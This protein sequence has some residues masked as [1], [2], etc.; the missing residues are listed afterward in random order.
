MKDYDIIEVLSDQQIK[1]L[2]AGE[3]QST[4]PDNLSDALFTVRRNVLT[5]SGIPGGIVNPSQTNGTA[6]FTDNQIHIGGHT[7]FYIRGVSL[8]TEEQVI[9]AVSDEEAVLLSVGLQTAISGYPTDIVRHSGMDFV[10]LGVKVGMTLVLEEGGDAGSHQIIKLN[11]GGLGVGLLQVDP[12]P[13]SPASNLRYKIVDEID[14][15]L[16]EPKTVRGSGT[17]LRTILGNLQVSTV[18]EID[19]LSM[20]ASTGDTLRISGNT[21]NA[22]DYDVKQISGTGNK[23]L[24]LGTDMRRTSSSEAW[25]LFKLQDG[26]QAPVVRITSVDILDSSKQPTGDTIP[27]AAPVD[28]QSSAFSN[29]GVGE[30][31]E[32]TDARVGILG[33]QDI[34]TP[35]AIDGKTL[36]ISINGGIFVTVTFSSPATP[37]DIVDQINTTLVDYKVAALYSYEGEIRLSLRSRNNWIVVNKL[38]TANALLGFSTVYNEDNRQVFSSLDWTAASLDIEA[39]KDAVYILTGDN[40]EFWYLQ[41]IESGSGWSRLLIVRVDEGGEAVFPLTDGRVS[42]RIGSRSFGKVRCYF[43]D[44]TS[45]E[46]RGAYRRAA[47]A[48]GVHEANKVFGTILTDE[49]PRTEFQLDLYGDQSAYFKFFPDPSLN[50]YLLPVSGETV[51]DNLLVT[52]G[53]PYVTSEQNPGLSPGQFSR[54]SEIDFLLREARPGDILEIT[55]M[56]LQSPTVALGSLVFPD[57]VVGKTLVF[58]LENGPERTVTFTNEVDGVTRLL[59]Q[60]NSQ[61][62]LTVAFVEDTGAAQYL[63]FEADVLFELRASGT[64]TAVLGMDA[65]VGTNEARAKG[66][67]VIGDVGYVSPPTSDHMRLEIASM[68]DNPSWTAFTAGQS[69]PSQHFKVYRPGVQRVSATD[70]ENNAEGSLY[71]ADIELVSFGPGDEFNIAASQQLQASNYKADGYRLTNTD[72]NLA[73]SA[74]EEL[75]MHLSRRILTP[76]TTDSPENMTQIS[77]QNIQVNYERSPLVEQIQNFATSELD[78]VLCANILVRHLVPHFVRFELNYQDGSQVAVV[79]SDIE[80]LI[81]GLLPDEVLEASAIVDIPRRRGASRVVLP[82]NLIGLVHNADRSILAHR[83]QDAISSGRLATFLP[84]V[85]TITRE[86]L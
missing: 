9:E 49:D 33:S 31:V 15:N 58:S 11:P 56:P 64:A 50:H 25:S 51:P 42:A 27:Y 80:D 3:Q 86:T 82:L 55:Y 78:R 75:H 85:L 59:A 32:A 29:I 67:Y 41:D 21:L 22:G 73:F 61:L 52:N 5:L 19:F 65:V 26:I 39:Q 4:L 79:Q 53:S 40:I 84:D 16:N 43:L 47:L 8:E 18:S 48:T 1:V 62:G 45:F 38:G 37:E 77:K 6:R 57:D 7:D 54:G 68:I 12:A 23:I 44:P 34:T 60:I 83:S 76:G 20:G 28:I 35:P 72:E 24:T 66:K 13:T 70:M 10:A 46:V 30:K 2:D 17:D 74:E 69:G 36:R 14:V 81:N 71:Y 63:R